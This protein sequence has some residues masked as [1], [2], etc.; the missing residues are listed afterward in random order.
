MLLS[1]RQPGQHMQVLRAD[2]AKAKMPPLQVMRQLL[3]FCAQPGQQTQVLLQPSTRDVHHAAV[4][5][6]PPLQSPPGVPCDGIT[7]LPNPAVF[8]CGQVSTGCSAWC[9]TCSQSIHVS[10][11]C[12]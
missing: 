12:P 5:P 9:L 2:A 3:E 1:P 11:L 10:L 6:Q 7:M 4:F 8:R